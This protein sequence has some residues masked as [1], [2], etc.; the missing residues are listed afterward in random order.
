MN[1]IQKMFK[2]NEKCDAVWLPRPDCTVLVK[3]QIVQ[4]PY[5][6]QY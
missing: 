6:L 2:W 1:L 5:C 3:E 4:K